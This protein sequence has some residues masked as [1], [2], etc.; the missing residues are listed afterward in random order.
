MITNQVMKRP[1]GN[2]LVEQRTKD[3]MFNATNLL[4]QWNDF[5]EHNDDTQKVGYVKKDLDDFFNNK[6]IKEF[7]DALMEEENL[8]TQ[9][10]AYVKSRARSDRG[11]GTWMHPIL[12]VN[13]VERAIEAQL[14]K[15][16]AKEHFHLEQL[17]SGLKY[18]SSIVEA[19]NQKNK[20]IQEAQR[21]LNEVAVKKAEAEKMLVQARAE[22]EANELKTASL[23]PAILKKMW[24]EKWDG[25]LPVYGNVPQMMM[26]T[27]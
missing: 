2:F 24:I 12:F 19:V 21:A 1:M 8:H 4:K 18:P 27:K 15:A 9:N 14:S 5:V 25:K 26:T 20:A 11:G 7:I 16:L 10:S 3:S 6:G 23:T 13:L 17:T 22:R